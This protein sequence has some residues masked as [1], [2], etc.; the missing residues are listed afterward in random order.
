MYNFRMLNRRPL[1]LPPLETLVPIVDLQFKHYTNEETRVQLRRMPP[2]LY[3]RYSGW[4]FALSNKGEI[5]A[6]GAH[7]FGRQESVRKQT[8][9]SQPSILCGGQNR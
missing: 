1:E 3:N 5:R 9:K 6:L 4:Y 2:L 8:H 7:Q